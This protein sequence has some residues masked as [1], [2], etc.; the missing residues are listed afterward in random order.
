MLGA[1]LIFQEL[2]VSMYVAT[3]ITI[4]FRLGTT[5]LVGSTSQEGLVTGFVL[6]AN[7]LQISL[8]L[9]STKHWTPFHGKYMATRSTIV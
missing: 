6:L 8:V 2:G 7:I 5:R 4:Q 9:A 3:N 1:K